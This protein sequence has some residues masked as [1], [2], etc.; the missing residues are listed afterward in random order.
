MLV[1][2]RIQRLRRWLQL[3][4]FWQYVLVLVVVACVMAYG[5]WAVESQR[6]LQEPRR[7]PDCYRVVVMD[8]GHRSIYYAEYDLSRFSSNDFPPF[9]C[10]KRKKDILVLSGQMSV[11]PYWIGETPDLP[12]EKP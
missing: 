5:R 6:P 11:E 10:I 1:K 2:G 12:P 7:S 8:G 3:G 4:G 9:Y